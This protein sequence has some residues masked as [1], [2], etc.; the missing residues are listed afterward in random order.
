[1]NDSVVITYSGQQ[2]S[3]SEEAAGFLEQDKCRGR[4]QS[5]PGAPLP[6]VR[7]VAGGFC[8]AV[9]WGKIW[10]GDHH[11][12]HFSGMFRSTGKK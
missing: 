10:R 2:I 7:A 8:G 3:V 9:K 12:G 6:A 11:W 1:M 5:P 4:K